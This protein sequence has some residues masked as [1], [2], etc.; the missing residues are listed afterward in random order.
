M[1]FEFPRLSDVQLEKLDKW[2]RNLLWEGTL[3]GERL[4]QKISVHRTKGRIVSRNGEEWIVQGVREVY[5]F[6]RTE[7]SHGE[8]SKIVLIGEGLQK[9]SIEKSLQTYLHK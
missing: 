1:S 6:K 5:E 4:S 7:I 9:D 8:R 3:I 2:I